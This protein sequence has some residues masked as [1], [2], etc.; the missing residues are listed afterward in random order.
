MISVFQ[1]A[2][3]TSNSLSQY[4]PVIGIIT[5]VTRIIPRK[6]IRPAGQLLNL[7]RCLLIL[8]LFQERCL[9]RERRQRMD[10][11]SSVFPSEPSCNPC[12]P[13]VGHV[14]GLCAYE[15]F[16]YRVVYLKGTKMKKLR[17]V[18]KPT[19]KFGPMKNHRA[20]KKGFGGAGIKFCGT[21]HDVAD[22]DKRITT[23]CPD[24][25]AV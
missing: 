6:D 10:L 13:I 24:C 25:D 18:F 4:N 11:T 2:C 8:T 17:K 14:C 7:K 19:T 1:E 20:V 23:T 15:Q 21:I 9:W 22:E 5:K 16:G 3:W 12:R